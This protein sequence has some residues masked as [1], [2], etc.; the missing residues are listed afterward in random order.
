MPL[1]PAIVS[2]ASGLFLVGWW[3][4][5]R[6]LANCRCGRCRRRQQRQP[7]CVL[8]GGDACAELQF[9]SGPMGGRTVVLED[10]IT[11][12]GSVASD[13]T[14]GEIVLADPAVS[15]E[16]VRIERSAGSFTLRD[17]GSTNGTFVNGL[18]HKELVLCG[19]DT[20]LIGNSE[21]VFRI[22]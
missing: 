20:I 9:R 16:H 21:A 5:R 2:S 7:R 22:G 15:Q 4:W 17:L 19:D 1:W 14:G 13:G 11:A 8:S 18:K 6:P 12:I 10:R 3:L